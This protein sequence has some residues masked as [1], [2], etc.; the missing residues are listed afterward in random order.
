[1]QLQI[2]IFSTSGSYINGVDGNGYIETIKAG[3]VNISQAV[4]DKYT[5]NT[6]IDNLSSVVAGWL[7]ENTTYGNVGDFLSNSDTAKIKEFVSFV[8][9]YSN[10]PAAYLA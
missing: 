5:D 3:K 2:I 1:M 6:Y 9:Q 4:A 8:W 7:R 10:N